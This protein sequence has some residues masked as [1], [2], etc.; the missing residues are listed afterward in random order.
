MESVSGVK[1]TSCGPI[2]KRFAV[3][4]QATKLQMPEMPASDS[5]RTV[6]AVTPCF[7]RNFLPGSSLKRRMSC[8][9]CS[10]SIAATA[11][12]LRTLWIHGTCLS[13]MPS[14]RCEPNPNW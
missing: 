6:S 11:S 5:I 12:V 1:S 8:M 2:P 13:P 7:W 9:T 10:S 4:M 14:I 3:W